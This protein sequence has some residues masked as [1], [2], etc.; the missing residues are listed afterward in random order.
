M[1]EIKAAVPKFHEMQEEIA[2]EFRGDIKKFIDR[3]GI[4]CAQDVLVILRRTLKRSGK[5]ISYERGSTKG[6]K[7]K[8][9]PL[10]LYRII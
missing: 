6:L 5:Y 10:Y 1:I 9:T 4:L 3:K 2:D 7:M 8:N